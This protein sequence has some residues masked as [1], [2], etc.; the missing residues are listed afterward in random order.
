MENNMPD[1]Q[2]VY[3]LLTANKNQLLIAI[4][5]TII[6]ALGA[7]ITI[8]LAP[9]YQDISLIKNSLEVQASDIGKIESTYVTKENLADI[10]EKLSEMDGRLQYLINLHLSK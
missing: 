3:N 7:Y 5:N 9:I 6:L 8:R 4:I 10:K 1:A 2:K